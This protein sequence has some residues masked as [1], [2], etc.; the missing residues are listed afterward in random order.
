MEII[1]RCA[2][3]HDAAILP[4]GVQKGVV[5]LSQHRKSAFAF[6]KGNHIR[7]QFGIPLA[8]V[9]DSERLREQSTRPSFFIQIAGSHQKG[10]CHFPQH[11]IR[12]SFQFCRRQV[13]SCLQQF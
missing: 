12:R 4:V 2:K 3:T 10:I 9:V 6:C 11:L 13:C 1:R 8:L 5:F 7:I